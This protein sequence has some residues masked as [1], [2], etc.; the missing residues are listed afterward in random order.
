MEWGKALKTLLLILLGSYALL[1]STLWYRVFSAQYRYN[2]LGWTDL[3][4][5][6]SDGDLTAVMALVDSGADVAD[7]GKP[8]VPPLFLAVMKNHLQV[9]SYLANYADVNQAGRNGV[10]A[11]Y[12][13]ATRGHLQAAKILVGKGAL[14]DLP[15]KDGISAALLAASEGNLAMLQFFVDNGAGTLA[16]ARP[17]QPNRALTAYRPRS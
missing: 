4:E 15:D 17:P 10:R 8:G 1:R 11:I 12:M 6:A 3:M 16:V 14:V 5:A 9:V 7:G 13:T 2:Q